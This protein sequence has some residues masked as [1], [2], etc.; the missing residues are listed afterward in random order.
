LGGKNR[1]AWGLSGMGD[2]LLTATSAKS[3][4]FRFGRE[5]GQGL[6]PAE[7]QKRI[8][9]VVEGFEAI[10]TARGLCSRHGVKTPVIDCIWRI[11]YKS[12]RPSAILRAAGFRGGY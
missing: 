2:L 9:T 1:T 11:V 8:K 10:R 5:I 6:S 4:N 7:A 12:D 3:R